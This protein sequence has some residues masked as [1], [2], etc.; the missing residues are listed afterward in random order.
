MR[1]IGVYMHPDR[2]PINVDEES[3]VGDLL[4][5]IELLMREQQASYRQHQS[6]IDSLCGITTHMTSGYVVKRR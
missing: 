4:D 1:K 3:S 5:V 6:D 2:G